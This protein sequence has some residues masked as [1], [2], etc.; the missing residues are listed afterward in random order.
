M[1]S[2]CSQNDICSVGDKSP[3]TNMIFWI[4]PS[5]EIWQQHYNDA[6]MS[7]MAPQITDFSLNR[8]FRR[9]SK[10]TSNLCI[11]GL[12]EGKSTVTGD[13]LH[14]G[15]V[16][17]KMFPFDDVIMKTNT[18]QS[19]RILMIRYKLIPKCTMPYSLNK[20]LIKRW[21]NLVHQVYQCYLSI[22]TITFW[23][24]IYTQ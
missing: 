2:S 20:N 16:T 4:I 1:V 3:D 17:R 14:K 9:R 24:P 12:C 13:S 8:L 6:M 23:K 22:T 5:K 10:R 7:V 18:I 19:E 11:T 15:P 21:W